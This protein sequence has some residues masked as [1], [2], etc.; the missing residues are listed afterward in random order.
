MSESGPKGRARDMELARIPVRVPR[1]YRGKR[2]LSA[3]R[4]SSAMSESGPKGR[5]GDMELARIPVRVPRLLAE[6]GSFPRKG[7]AAQ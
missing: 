4:R 7:G 6:S 2:E 5:A 3:K 1:L